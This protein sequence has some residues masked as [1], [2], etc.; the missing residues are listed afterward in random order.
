MLLEGQRS[1]GPA[2][3]RVVNLPDYQP[4]APGAAKSTPDPVSYGSSDL[5]VVKQYAS[6]S[7]D[8]DVKVYGRTSGYIQYRR[9]VNGVIEKT[10][11]DFSN[12]GQQIYSG[13]ERMQN[14]RET[15][16]ERGCQYV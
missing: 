1:G 12:D 4:A 5:S 11:V 7:H 16:R 8:I 10:Y 6:A 13:S 15:C 9:T 14:G 3:I 2:R